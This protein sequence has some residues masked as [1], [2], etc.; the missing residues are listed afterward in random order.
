MFGRPGD[1]PGLLMIPFEG[2]IGHGG[3][4][5]KALDLGAWGEYTTH[6]TRPSLP[7]F[8]PLFCC[9]TNLTGCQC[10]KKIVPTI[11]RCWSQR[12]KKQKWTIRREGVTSKQFPSLQI[13]SCT[14]FFQCCNTKA[15]TPQR[16]HI[17]HFDP[18]QVHTIVTCFR[19]SSCCLSSAWGVQ[20]SVSQHINCTIQCSG[21]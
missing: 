2:Q 18:F 15:N 9:Y 1:W 17:F 20:C 3:R 7:P 5:D 13:V 21:V 19:A 6:I 11:Y 12:G 16:V 4:L 14:T 8:E 10:K